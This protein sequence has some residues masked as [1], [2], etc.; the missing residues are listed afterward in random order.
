M[1]L[2]MTFKDDMDNLKM[3]PMHTTDCCGLHNLLFKQDKLGLYGSTS[4][5]LL[6]VLCWTKETR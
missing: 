5:R 2:K 1:L 6:S 3:N 4:V